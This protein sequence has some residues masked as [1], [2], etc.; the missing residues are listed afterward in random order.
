MFKVGIINNRTLF[1]N[2]NNIITINPYS[3]FN[4]VTK[5]CFDAFCTFPEEKDEMINFKFISYNNK[6]IYRNNDQIYAIFNNEIYL[7]FILIVLNN[8]NNNNL[9][10]TLLHKNLS[11]FMKQIGLVEAMKEINDNYIKIIFNKSYENIINKKKQFTDLISSLINFD[12][13]FQ[14]LDSNEIHK[15]VYYLI[16]ED[17][18]DNFKNK[19]NYIAQLNQS[20]IN[21]LSPTIKTMFNNFINNISENDN[22]EIINQ[23]SKIVNYLNDNTNN[24][25]IKFYDNYSFINEDV[26]SN[27][28]KIFN[29]NIEIKTFAYIN[30]NYFLI[31]YDE[32]NF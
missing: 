17:W 12:Y 32:N 22:I 20:N 18:L 9:Y 15:K 24:K 31:Y 5:E 19:L 3:N 29:W 8:P 4:F 14:I 16:N 10:F 6:L 28:I 1:K 11:V 13:N 26:W 7:N 2:I 27:L 21:D 30:K 25:I 23:G